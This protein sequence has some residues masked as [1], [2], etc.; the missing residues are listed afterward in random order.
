MDAP[1]QSEKHGNAAEA[2]QN[3]RFQPMQLTQ[4]A[5]PQLQDIPPQPAA[6]DTGNA[7]G[8]QFRPMLLNTHAAKGKQASVFSHLGLNFDLSSFFSYYPM[9]RLFGYSFEAGYS[10]LNRGLQKVHGSGAGKLRMPNGNQKNLTWLEKLTT[11]IYGEAQP[12]E[13]PIVPETASPQ[14]NTP[15]DRMVS[16]KDAPPGNTAKQPSA[17]AANGYDPKRHEE[18]YKS[19]INYAESIAFTALALW[20]SKSSYD[21]MRDNCKLAVA[22]ELGKDVKSIGLND[23]RHSNNPLVV[24]AINR[25]FWQSLLRTGGGLSFIHSLWAGIMVNSAVI[26]AERT[27]FYRPI[28]Y[29]VLS[30]TVNDVQMNSLGM[31]A[32]SDVVDNLIRVLQAE[33]FD[34]RQQMI[35]REQVE[36]MRPTLDL[37]AE[38]VINK[39]FGITGMMYIMGGGVIIPEDPQQT[40]T[41]YM[42]V[43]DIG[44]SGV[45]EEAKHI[46]R[47]T[48]APSTKIWEARLAE[49]AKGEEKIA[50]SARRDELLRERRAILARGPLHSTPGGDMDPNARYGAS[51]QL[52]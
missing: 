9:L 39:R 11:R 12:G 20:H 49:S 24:S 2:E 19:R 32:K 7:K 26:T 8:T 41:N 36:A 37:I 14:P 46:K 40:Q 16:S 3:T 51:I 33:R 23:L 31:E 50:E 52:F 10:Q 22:A 6:N 48:H 13:R 15:E 21:Q 43:R 38:D 27:V 25:S 42:H 4:S 18:Y 47:T 5:P 45:M 28:A 34:H 30:K 17:P 1:Q 44:V 35:P 29:D